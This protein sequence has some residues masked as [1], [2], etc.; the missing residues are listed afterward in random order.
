MQCTSSST[1]S[2]PVYAAFSL[3]VPGLPRVL[4]KQRSE[5]HLDKLELF[6]WSGTVGL[7]FVLARFDSLRIEG[8]PVGALL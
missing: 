6:C 3:G 1:D 7:Y 4:K 5:V 2:E 8:L